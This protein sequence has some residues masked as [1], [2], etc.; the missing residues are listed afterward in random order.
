VSTVVADVHGDRQPAIDIP[1][2]SG[3]VKGKLLDPFAKASLLAH[4]ATFF[5]FLFC[6][7][8]PNLPETY[9]AGRVW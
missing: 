5:L 6:H 9:P 8:P 2:V 3:L 1:F 7:P 4:V